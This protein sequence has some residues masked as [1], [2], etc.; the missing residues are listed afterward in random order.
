MQDYYSWLLGVLYRIVRYPRQSNPRRHTIRHLIYFTQ[1]DSKVGGLS[2]P[3]ALTITFGALKKVQS[4]VGGSGADVS[5]PREWTIHLHSE[6][7]GFS[8]WLVCECEA[9]NTLSYV[10]WRLSWL[11]KRL[12]NILEHSYTPLSLT[13][14]RGCIFVSWRASWCILS[15][16]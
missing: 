9:I 5:T 3:W 16:G 14:L 11:W 13:F 6:N 8:Q 2:V 7:M 15:S 1:Y 4:I 10:A 12:L